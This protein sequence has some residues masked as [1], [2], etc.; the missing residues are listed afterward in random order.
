MGNLSPIAD[1]PP[2]GKNKKRV[3]STYGNDLDYSD[4][5]N[6]FLLSDEDLDEDAK[7]IEYMD[8]RKKGSGRRR[9]N[10]ILCQK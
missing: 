6:D 3:G 8:T 4:D 2:I 9:G 7:V 5:D 10:L 1:S